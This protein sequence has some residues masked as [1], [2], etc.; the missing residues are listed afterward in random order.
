[1]VS[2]S[3]LQCVTLN[4]NERNSAIPKTAQTKETIMRSSCPEM[5]CI[6]G[7]LENTAKFTGK[8][9]KAVACNVIKKET[10]TQLF[11]VNFAKLLRKIKKKKK[12]TA[13]GCFCTGVVQELLGNNPRGISCQKQGIKFS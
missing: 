13:G 1:M 10:L 4:R 8:V 6:W 7:V 9:R 12:N 5:F 3:F 11:P 2:T